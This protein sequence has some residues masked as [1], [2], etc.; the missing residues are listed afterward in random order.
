ME[1]KRGKCLKTAEK[2]IKR[3]IH[4]K[5]RADNYE[6]RFSEFLVPENLMIDTK[7]FALGGLE[8]KLAELLTAYVRHLGFCR[9]TRPAS[10][11]RAGTHRISQIE[12]SGRANQQ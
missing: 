2:S 7:I 11:G 4:P 6:N 3:R 8:A 12:V 1:K 9:F 5:Y 10:P